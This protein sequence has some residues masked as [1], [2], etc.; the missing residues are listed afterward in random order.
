[1]KKILEVPK[2]CQ[3]RNCFQRIFF[4]KVHHKFAVPEEK[5]EQ[6]SRAFRKPAAQFRLDLLPREA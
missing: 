3:N 1:M 6:Q 5:F 2:P 4:A